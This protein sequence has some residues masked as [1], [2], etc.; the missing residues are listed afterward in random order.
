MSGFLVRKF[1]KDSGTPDTRE[2]IGKLSSVVGIVV[3]L[4]L[5]AGKMVAGT[6]AGSIA[7]TG[8]AVNNLS[9]AGSSV[10]SL[11]SFKL[12]GKPADAKHPFGHAR[13]EYIASMVVAFLILLLGVELMQSSVN[14][15][16]AP[17]AISFSWLTVIVLAAS[18]LAKLWLY[19]FGK[20]LGRQIQSTVIQATAADSLSDVLATTAVLLSTILSPLLGVALDGYMGA[21]VSL[22]I[23]Y[24][25]VGIIR[26]AFSNLLGKA[27]ELELVERIHSFVR[28]YDGVLSVHDLMVH[29]YGP[30]RCFASVHVEVDANEDILKSHD[31]IDNIERDILEKYGIHLVIHLD[32]VVMGDAE[33]DALRAQVSEILAGI[34][35][36]L[37]MHDFRMV[38]GVTHSNLIFD[39]ILPYQ[40]KLNEKELAHRIDV[41]L[42]QRDPSLFAV[43]SFDR[44]F[45][46]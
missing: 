2:K 34:D 5:S 20:S 39:V 17:D 13:V 38:R 33:A 9:D 35:P 41:Q 10:I 24:A 4:L 23:L 29:S 32:P 45:I 26:E 42:K 6:L 19:A 27:P 11:I 1:V 7:V 22:F 8:D 14:K 21:V 15:I 12:A 30:S 28:S 37:T 31:L 36:A 16:L 18:I 44:S 25:G 43:I 3:N 40:Y 46:Q